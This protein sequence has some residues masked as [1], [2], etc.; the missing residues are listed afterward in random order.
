[1]K[2][3]KKVRMDGRRQGRQKKGRRKLCDQVLDRRKK[4]KT[5]DT[6]PKNTVR[7][8]TTRTNQ[9]TQ[10]TGKWRNEEKRMADE[11]AEAEE[12]EADEE[13]IL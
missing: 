3:K 10:L 2:E 1:M 7:T 11:K 9:L 8:V 13:N 6:R 12:T 5:R 4:R